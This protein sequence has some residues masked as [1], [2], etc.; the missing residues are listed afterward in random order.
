MKQYRLKIETPLGV[1][2]SKAVEGS[3]TETDLANAQL[4]ILEMSSGQYNYLRLTLGSGQEIVLGKEV[5][6]NSIFSIVEVV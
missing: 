1:Y 3:I 5:L 6:V 2:F 4:K